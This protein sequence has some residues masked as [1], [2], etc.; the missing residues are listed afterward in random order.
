MNVIK[1]VIAGMLFGIWP[2]LMNRSGL[3]GSVASFVFAFVVLIC[4]FLFSLT[5]PMEISSAHWIFAIS[6]GVIGAIGLLLFNGVIAKATVQN[7]GLLFVIMLI[8]QTAIPAV[9]QSIM[10]GGI[11]FQ[12]I[13]GFLLAIVSIVLLITKD[14]F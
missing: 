6:A 11:S 9:Y 3:S 8:A 13:L 14:R 5:Q 7:V 2:L 12:K 4:V 10:A 1:I